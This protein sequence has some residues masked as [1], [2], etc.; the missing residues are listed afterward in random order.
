MVYFF[1]ID[2]EC[3]LYGSALP[4]FRFVGVISIHKMHRANHKIKGI[5]L[6][7]CIQLRFI[8]AGQPRFHTLAD[9]QPRHGKAV[10]G[11]PVP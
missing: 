1:Q 4:V 2:T 9:S 11:R 3:F 7:K 8:P 10:I 6:Q 5:S